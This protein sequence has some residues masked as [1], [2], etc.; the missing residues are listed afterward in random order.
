MC[1]LLNF[2]EIINQLIVKLLK[3]NNNN[4]KIASI[5][6]YWFDYKNYTK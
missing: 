3:T 6:F 5:L 2:Y 4:I 1:A